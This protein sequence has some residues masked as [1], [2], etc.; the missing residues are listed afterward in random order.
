MNVG[1]GSLGS[2]FCCLG[3]NSGLVKISKFL[4]YAW[5]ISWDSCWDKK[6]NNGAEFLLTNR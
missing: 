3:I 4:D 5:D 2:L 1:E 6:L